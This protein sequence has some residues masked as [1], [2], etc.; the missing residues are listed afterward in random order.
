MPLAGDFDGD[1]K[2]DIA[3]FR[4]SDRTWYAL[5]SSNGSF[6]ASVFGLTGDIP[7]QSMFVR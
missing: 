2:N 7:V 3:V 4:Q 1:G 6:R 5:N